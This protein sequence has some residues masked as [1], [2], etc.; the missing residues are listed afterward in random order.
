MQKFSVKERIFVFSFSLYSTFRIEFRFKFSR[1]LSL[2]RVTY[3]SYPKSKKGSCLYIS[4][5]HCGKFCWLLFLKI[6][7]TWNWKGRHLQVKTFVQ[8]RR[9][10]L[11]LTLI[12]SIS[13]EIILLPLTFA[14][15]LQQRCRCC[16]F[17][18]SFRFWSS[19]SL[20]YFQLF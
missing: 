8:E 3:Q 6:V 12:Y 10:R 2:I 1:F 7:G 19:S 16:M 9:K 20:I 11:W 4:V 13:N 14:S 18:L 5:E 15:H 17:L